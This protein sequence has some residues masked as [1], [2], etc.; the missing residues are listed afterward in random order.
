MAPS[1][2]DPPA[3]RLL[4]CPERPRGAIEIEFLTEPDELGYS[5]LEHRD[6]GAVITLQRSGTGQQ[7]WV[8]TEPQMNQGPMGTLGSS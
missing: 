8:V 1:P 6:L 7:Q 5:L 3:R 2:P 4:G